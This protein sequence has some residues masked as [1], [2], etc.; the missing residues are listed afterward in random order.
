MLKCVI[1]GGPGA[2]K[3]EIMVHLTQILEERGYKIWVRCTIISV[4]PAPGP[5]V[6]THFNIF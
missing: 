2:G 3:T 6:I 5:P 1:T 4:F